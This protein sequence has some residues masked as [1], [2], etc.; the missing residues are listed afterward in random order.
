MEYK[1]PPT[2]PVFGPSCP[3]C[4]LFESGCD[5]VNVIREQVGGSITRV[6]IAMHD[7]QKKV[8]ERSMRIIENSFRYCPGPGPDGKGIFR[9]HPNSFDIDSVGKLS[10]HTATALIRVITAQEMVN[11]RPAIPKLITSPASFLPNPS[12]DKEDPELNELKASRKT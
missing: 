2:A 8:Y 7:K 12:Q 3:T 1:L 5:G 9:R 6:S 4:V 11:Q 10:P